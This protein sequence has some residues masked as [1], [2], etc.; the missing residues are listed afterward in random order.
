MVND[1]D[2]NFAVRLWKEYSKEGIK[3][4]LELLIK[5]N[6]EDCMNLRPLMEFVYSELRA[7]V[8][9]RYRKNINDQSG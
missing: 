1:N 3:K 4:S 5:Y 2:R 7:Q 8:F 6:S 9:E